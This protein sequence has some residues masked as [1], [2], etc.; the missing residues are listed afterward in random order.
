MMPV[1]KIIQEIAAVLNTPDSAD[2]L[3]EIQDRAELISH[4]LKFVENRPA[5]VC[6]EALEP[7]TIAGY[8]VPDL[9]TVAGGITVITD[10]GQV[11]NI[12]SWE[13]LR[14]QDPD[15]LV[16][17]AEGFS[18]ERTLR[19]M[20]ILLQQPGFGDLKSVKNKRLYIA[21]GENYFYQTNPHLIEAIEILAEIIYPK[22]FIFG[23]EGEGWIKFDV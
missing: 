3:E 16:V 20:D 7:I 11:V 13:D 9:V 21:D 17:M 4:K 8:L 6:L 23:H 15:I 19:A 18:I 22:Q 2:V 5:V 14:L 1:D 10:P 12:I